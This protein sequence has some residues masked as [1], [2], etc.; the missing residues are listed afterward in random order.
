MSQASSIHLLT[1][2]EH[3]RMDNRY[4]HKFFWDPVARE[5]T[6][7]SRNDHDGGDVLHWSYKFTRSQAEEFLE[8]HKDVA[9]VAKARREFRI[10]EV[11][12]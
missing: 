9:S 11:T 10:G 7:R 12:G 2:N 3:D 4:V 8:R 6:R 5:I 1:V